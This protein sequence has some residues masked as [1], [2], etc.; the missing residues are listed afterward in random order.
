MPTTDDDPDRRGHQD[1][2]GESASA[3][4]AEERPSVGLGGQR[5]ARR[6]DTE[7]TGANAAGEPP[8]EVVEAHDSWDRE[9]REAIGMALEAENEEVDEVELPY[10]L[11]LAGRVSIG[12]A[13]FGLFLSVFGVGTAFLDIQPL[14]TVSMFFSLVLVTGAMIFAVVIRAYRSDFSLPSPGA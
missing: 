11:E 2:A 5:E 3:P 7:P 9:R 8:A 13:L 12:V 4:G 10:L 6:L 14:G 1:H